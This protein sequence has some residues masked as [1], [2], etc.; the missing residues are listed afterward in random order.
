MRRAILDLPPS[1]ILDVGC[2]PG[3]VVAYLRSHGLDCWGCEV[4]SPAVRDAAKDFT[5]TQNDALELEGDF[6]QSVGILLLLDV[7]EHLPD[8]SAFLKDLISA[9]PAVH[10]IVATVP[11]RMELWT[12][13]DGIYGHFLRYDRRQLAELYQK[14]GIET[15]RLRYFFQA[16][17][18]PLLLASRLKTRATSVQAPKVAWPHAAL[19]KWFVFESSIPGTGWIPGSSLIATGVPR[20]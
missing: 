9:Y 10:G 1:R 14:S 4:G 8:P 3:I 12:E 2:G 7:L 16:V 11:A 15:K 19:A 18:P 20:R 6:R 13:W 17:Y 5:W